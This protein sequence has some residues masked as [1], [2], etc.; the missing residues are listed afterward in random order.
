MGI[1]VMVG[2][3]HHTAGDVG[4]MVTDTLQ[5]VQQVGPD[6]AGFDAAAALLEPQDVVD[7]KLFL[8]IVNDLLQRLH[9]VGGQ[10]IVVPEGPEG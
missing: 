8:Q 5:G 10:K 3:V 4:A 6:K 9:L 2:H 1:P 7:A